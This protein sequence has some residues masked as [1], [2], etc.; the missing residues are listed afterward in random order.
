[1]KSIVADRSI[2]FD[3][4][5]T[6]YELD[7][8]EF[9]RGGTFAEQCEFLL[10]YVLLAPSTHNT[11]PWKF[12]LTESGIDVY[13][14]YS[15]RLPTVD[16]GNRELLMSIG[17]AI[18]NLRIAAEHFGFS[19]RVDYNHSGA[20]ERPL[21]QTSLTPRDSLEQSVAPLD[22]LFAS[23]VKRH[24]NRS[25]FLLSRIPSA[26]LEHFRTI[27]TG[28]RAGLS[29]STDGKVNEQVANLVAAAERMQLADPA[30][31]K[32]LAEWVR[33]NWTERQDGMTGAALGASNLSS[34]LSP[35]ATRVL[36]LGRLRAAR[37]KN[38]CIEAPG[39][40]VVQSEDSV[41]HWLDAGE[42]LEQLLLTATRE[43]LHCSYFNM[44]VQVPDARLRL[45]ALL[46]LS[47]W[48]QILIRIGFSLAVPA[49]TPRRPLDEV[50]IQRIVRR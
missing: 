6:P 8:R 20:S 36:D 39:L 32:D 41:P 23:I 26:V 38:L 35:W 7:E 40:V 22:S 13:A 15:R 37:D 14:D 43:G 21:A 45:R 31:R 4:M 10:R 5:K 25:Q 27:D 12:R 2:A 44:P 18:W 9:P 33:P 47:S 34:A 42:L 29:I 49:I 28:G 3:P 19:C 11:Q 1:L 30:F 24:T 46:G 16:P 50:V 48:P 17:A